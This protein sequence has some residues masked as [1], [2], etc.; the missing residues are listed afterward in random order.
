MATTYNQKTGVRKFLT[1]SGYKDT[2]IGYDGNRGMVTLQGKD[3]YSATP[4]ADSSTYGNYG[5][6]SSSLN[7]FR[8]QQQK[9]QLDPLVATLTNRANATPAAAYTPQAYAGFNPNTS[10]SFQ[11]A[12]QNLLQDANIATNN[13]M[14]GMG[15]R[16]IGNS[17]AATDR[18]YQLQQKA[19]S[20][21]SN[22]L[23]P[24][25]EQQDYSRWRDTVADQRYANETE[26]A[27]GQDQQAA[28]NQLVNYL[29]GSIQQ[30]FQNG[31]T[32]AG[33]TGQYNGQNTMAQRGANLDAAR[34]VGQDRG[35]ILE[36]VDDY[37]NLYYQPGLGL[38]YTAQQA[39][40]DNQY[41][42]DRATRNDFENDRNYTLNER[43]TN[44]SIANSSASRSRQTAADDRENSVRALEG[45]I[46]NEL[47]QLDNEA[48]VREWLRMNQGYITGQLG[49][50]GFNQIAGYALSDF[51]NQAKSTATADKTSSSLR[52]QAVEMAMKD[53]LW[54]DS[55]TNKQALVNQYVQYLMGQ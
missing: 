27:R 34:A 15:A 24:Q 55:K 14:V 10:A 39:A 2:D 36:P 9:A 25:Y 5:D 12:K 16:G 18:G 46:M 26:Y 40:A 45:D 49:A 52:S 32:E 33:V 3:F 21:I 48:D 53:P 43:Q 31:I 37:R 35:L 7:N 50:E 23:M 29:A 44:A 17:S 20:Q 51:T 28:L 30:N 47:S 38:N 19:V 41:R 54:M 11:A 6:L 8:T 22:Q 4:E 1:D 42:D 13:A